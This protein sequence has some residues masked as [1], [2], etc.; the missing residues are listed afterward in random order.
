MTNDDRYN[1]WCKYYTSEE[2]TKETDFS[3]CDATLESNLLIQPV[4]PKLSKPLPPPPPKPIMTDNNVQNKRSA[5]VLTSQ[6]CLQ[7]LE[8]KEKAK[9]K[10]QEEKEKKK[11]ERELKRAEKVKASEAKETISRQKKDK[12]KQKQDYEL[13]KQ[14]KACASADL[15]K[16]QTVKKKVTNPRKSS[17]E[18]IHLVDNDNIELSHDI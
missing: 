18:G 4:P 2:P 15:R 8:E 7:E 13:N 10:K 5:R 3:V 9:H 16:D 1:L 14:K 12:T 11:Q 17:V 6:A